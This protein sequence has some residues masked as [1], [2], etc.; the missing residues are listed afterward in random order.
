MFLERTDQVPPSHPRAAE[1][2]RTRISTRDSE[3]SAKFD[4]RLS[5]PV[6][7]LLSCSLGKTTFS[8]DP[9]PALRLADRTLATGNHAARAERRDKVRLLGPVSSECP[10]VYTAPSGTWAHAVRG[11]LLCP[12]TARRQPT[13]TGAIDSLVGLGATTPR[14]RCRSSSPEFTASDLPQSQRR[15]SSNISMR[16]IRPPFAV[17]SKICA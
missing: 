1:S 11:G 15:N 13:T 8:S 3:Q 10:L 5:G 9:L 6:S 4:M 14:Q 16:Q 7:R 17:S 2:S 12:P